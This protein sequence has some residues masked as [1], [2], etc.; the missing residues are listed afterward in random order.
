MMRKFYK[1]REELTVTNDSI[2]RRTNMVITES[3]RDQAMALAHEAIR[4]LLKQRCVN[5]TLEK[6]KH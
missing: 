2:L 6:V 3:L 5:W 1:V 4:G